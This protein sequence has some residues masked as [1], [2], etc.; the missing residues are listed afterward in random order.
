MRPASSCNRLTLFGISTILFLADAYQ[1]YVPREDMTTS[2]FSTNPHS[3]K[4]QFVSQLS[5]TH[6][7]VA[8]AG[9]AAFALTATLHRKRVNAI[10]QL[11]E[12]RNQSM[13]LQNVCLRVLDP[14]ADFNALSAL[15]AGRCKILH[16][17]ETALKVGFGPDEYQMPPDFHP[18]V[19]AFDRYGGHATITLKP[20]QQ[21]ASANT[22]LD[23]YR[24]GSGLQYIKLGVEPIRISKAIA[25]GK[26]T[27]VALKRSCPH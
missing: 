14:R 10:G 16:T 25:A 3:P 20:F 22:K 19:S 4:E 17:K 6:N 7:S 21:G 24:W 1:L 13:V 12:L 27:V 18:G 23:E 11:F 5:T 26:C 15:T 8:A 2:R 9:L